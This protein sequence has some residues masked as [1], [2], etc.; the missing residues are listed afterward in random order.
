MID[1]S[2]QNLEVKKLFL[3]E[4]NTQFEFLK[5]IFTPAELQLEKPFVL[6]AL[7]QSRLDLKKD[8]FKAKSFRQWLKRYRDKHHAAT[9]N[10][11]VAMLSGSQLS[12]KSETLKFQF[13]DPSTIKKEGN[14]LFQFVK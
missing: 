11:S 8:D 14:S 2:P 1:L 5:F 6:M 3:N 12:E 4:G 7:A 9:K 10:T 13:T